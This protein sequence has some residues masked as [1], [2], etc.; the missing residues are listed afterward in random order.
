M[1]SFAKPD[2]VG[3]RNFLLNCGNE[4]DNMRVFALLTGNRLGSRHLVL[5]VEMMLALTL[6]LLVA[7]AVAQF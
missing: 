4:G 7:R 6:V 5:G 3:P 1:L 2:A